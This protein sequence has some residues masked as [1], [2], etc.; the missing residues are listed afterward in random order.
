MHEVYA[1]YLDGW[2]TDSGLE[3]PEG[4]VV[5]IGYPLEENALLNTRVF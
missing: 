5:Q 2:N 4:F 3:D 1:T